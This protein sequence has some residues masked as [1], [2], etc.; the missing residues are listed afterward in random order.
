M[1][2]S[3]SDRQAWVTHSESLW[4]RAHELARLH[5]EHDP[6]DLYH[7]LRSLELTPSERLCAG[8]QRGRLRTYAR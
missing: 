7:A 2:Q 3:L 8:L 5:P 1:G 6:S 4:R